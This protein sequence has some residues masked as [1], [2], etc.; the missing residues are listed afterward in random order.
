MPALNVIC[1]VSVSIGIVPSLP[2]SSIFRQLEAFSHSEPPGASLLEL[3]DSLL[4]LA[5]SLLEL[6]DSLLEDSLL[7]LDSLL[8]DEQSGKLLGF[9]PLP[10]KHSDP[11]LELEDS[12]L[13]ELDS[14]LELVDS[15][16]LE[17]D[18]SLELE[19]SSL[20]DESLLDEE[21]SGKLF[22]FAPLPLKHSTPLPASP[23]SSWPVG[24]QAASTN[25]R[26]TIRPSRAENDRRHSG[27]DVFM[28]SLSNKCSIYPDETASEYHPMDDYPLR[29]FWKRHLLTQVPPLRTI[30]RWPR[31]G[32]VATSSISHAGPNSSNR[33]IRVP[34]KETT[35]TTCRSRDR[36]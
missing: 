8:D 32:G 35:R 34:W 11:S 22:G 33:G 18:S 26:T 25:D 7:E 2:G 5:D 20:L 14:S 17:L 19:D 1:V 10:L 15:S 12:S 6:A 31:L 13:L 28:D 23:E 16:L 3:D 9:A 4:E 36:W 30:R 27:C 29:S 21:Q 24:P